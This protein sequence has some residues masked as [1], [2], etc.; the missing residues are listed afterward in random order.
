[1]GLGLGSRYGWWAAATVESAQ[2]C[3]RKGLKPV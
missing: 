1:M 2:H 3:K